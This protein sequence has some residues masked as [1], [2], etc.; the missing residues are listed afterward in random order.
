[1]HLK[2]RGNRAMLYRSSWIPKG[3]NGNTHGYSIQQF[4]GSLPVD[5]PKL[6]ADLADVLSEE[7][8]A[9]LQAKVLQPARLAAEKTKRSAEQREADP[10][11][12][13]EEATRLT[14]E[15]AYRSELWAVP[16]AKV[17]AVQSALANVRTIVQ[18]Q[19]PPIAPVQSPEPSK[20]DPLKDLLD[21][22]KE[23]RGAVLAGRYGTAPAEGVRSTYAYKMWAD[24]FEAVGGSGGNS[25]MNAL[26]VKGF[27][28]TR[29]K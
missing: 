13:L 24:I 12:R 15:A 6:P 7:E 29:C 5:S 10:V 1:M 25:L 9:L 27:A 28:K 3:T 26:Q 18:V 22:I 17:A 16:N 4:V 20:V 2:L 11:W 19:A 14:L 21:A 8:V 23:A